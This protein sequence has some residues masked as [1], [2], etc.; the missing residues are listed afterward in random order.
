MDAQTWFV[1]EALKANRFP[2]RIGGHV[3]LDF[4]NTAEFRGSAEQKEFLGS[5]ESILAWC[6]QAEL[7]AD[8][9]AA[10]LSILGSQQRIKAEQVFQRTLALREAVY[11]LCVALIDDGTQPNGD[12]ALLNRFLDQAQQHRQLASTGKSFSWVWTNAETDLSC[13]LW[14]LALAAAELLTSEKLTRLRQCPNCGWLFLDTSRNGKRRWC[15]MDFCGSQV[16][17]RRQYE[18]KKAAS[19]A[20]QQ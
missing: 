8:D 6:W 12:L 1:F 10:Q 5:Y 19:A 3:A 14:V 11:R 13:I 16:K 18:R 9:E 7:I 15:S 2:I 20:P 4:T 17:S